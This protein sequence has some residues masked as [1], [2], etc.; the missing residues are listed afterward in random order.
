MT[1]HV[2][3]DKKIKLNLV[4]IAIVLYIENHHFIIIQFYL[5]TTD[6]SMTGRVSTARSSSAGK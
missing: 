3:N 1:G 4:V 5:Y 6:F 2:F